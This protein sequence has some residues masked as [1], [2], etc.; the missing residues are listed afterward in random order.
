MKLNKL[1]NKIL[2]ENSTSTYDYGCVMLY[3]SFPEMDEIHSLIDSRDVYSEVGDISFGLEDEPHCTLLYGLH[4]EVTVDDVRKITDKY[5]YYTSK[6]HKLSLF[7]SDK[8]DVLKYD[9]VGDNL[10]ETNEDLRKF[11]H[12]TSFPEYKPH[13]T[14]GYLKK[15]RGM[16]Y[17][18]K[19]KMRGYGEFWVAPQYIVY[20]HTDGS[21]NKINISID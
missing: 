12:T 8:Y 4:S 11:P 21:K 3:Y 18:N 15:G 20:T 13:L 19:L 5:T 9:V 7:Q 16:N 17:V 2:N 14:V 10:H 1:L 6:L